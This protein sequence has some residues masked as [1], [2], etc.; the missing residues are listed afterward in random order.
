M[1]GPDEP[2]PTTEELYAD[3]YEWLLH[4]DSASRVAK[5]AVIPRLHCVRSD[6]RYG[7]KGFQKAA[8]IKSV[9]DQSLPIEP[10][11][12]KSEMAALRC[13]CRV[14]CDGPLKTRLDGAVKKLPRSYASGDSFRHSSTYQRLLH[15]AAELLRLEEA[16][17]RQSHAA[18]PRARPN[19][20]ASQIDR[21]DGGAVEPARSRSDHHRITTTSRFAKA[22]RDFLGGLLEPWLTG[23]RDLADDQ[24][25]RSLWAVARTMH[26]FFS[27]TWLVV[28]DAYDREPD[29]GLVW[30]EGVIGT[31]RPG[32]KQSL[33]T[34]Y[35]AVYD[36][37]HH[38]YTQQFVLPPLADPEIT[39]LRGAAAGT[40]IITGVSQERF[41]RRLLQSNLG[42]GVRKRWR[43]W[44]EECS[45]PINVPPSSWSSQEHAMSVFEPACSVHASV[46]LDYGPSFRNLEQRTDSSRQT[47]SSIARMI[48]ELHRRYEV[49]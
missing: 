30:V 39:A 9:L 3:L 44:L 20:R 49:D 42:A 28:N 6:G 46:L 24:D 41:L 22:K 40:T 48:L 13:L 18:M 29:P 38:P 45:C 33:L 11:D 17:F 14:D 47:E 43:Q 5:M 15:Q 36:D 21:S 2:I 34:I 10:G 27:D 35:T 4:T 1:T 37:R 8:A 32:E 23:Q 31:V 16:N 25:I 19:P 12:R 26:Y 7:P